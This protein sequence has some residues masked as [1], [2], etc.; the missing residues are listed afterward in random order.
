MKSNEAQLK[1][2]RPPETPPLTDQGFVSRTSRPNVGTGGGYGGG[3]TPDLR[4]LL[5]GF[6]G[7]VMTP[8]VAGPSTLALRDVFTPSGPFTPTA[9]FTPS[10]PSFMF[11]TYDSSHGMFQDVLQ[12]GT[13]NPLSTPGLVPHRTRESI[14]AEQVA[15]M[16]ALFNPAPLEATR[17]ADN[18]KCSTLNDEEDELEGTSDAQSSRTD[19]DAA[20]ANQTSASRSSS[21]NGALAVDERSEAQRRPPAID[22][23]VTVADTEHSEATSM[24]L[25]SP[26]LGS[27]GIQ[28]STS[29]ARH[30][31]SPNDDLD[32]SD[33]LQAS[34]DGLLLDEDDEDED[35]DDLID[36]EAEDEDI[37]TPDAEQVAVDLNATGTR[38]GTQPVKRKRGLRSS[39]KRR[40]LAVDKAGCSAEQ[41][42]RNRAAALERLRV[43]KSLRNYESKI[44]YACR[45]KI[46]LVRP[47][48][49]GRFATK[50]EV[51]EAKRLGIKLG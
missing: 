29:F 6:S 31:E 15:A 34:T 4:T 5:R 36:H 20:A 37:A 23:P 44:R 2:G 7:D 48:I 41:A 47:R 35:G 1:T 33:T 25:G 11:T 32:V 21:P 30:V 3:Y 13:T 40:R 28:E 45:K 24:M 14:R 38:S 50:E 46:A 49:N 27:D 39:K 10:S 19:A 9:P 42:R 18:L 51:A 8:G 12:A 43:K 22:S 16:S 17:N 26:C